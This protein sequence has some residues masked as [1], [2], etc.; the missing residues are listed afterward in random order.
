MGPQ[1][2]KAFHPASTSQS[3]SSSSQ[4]SSNLNRP[5]DAI[6]AAPALTNLVEES[7]ETANKSSAEGISLVKNADGFDAV[8]TN[9]DP[10]DV[11]ERTEQRENRG[12]GE[13]DFECWR[14]QLLAAFIRMM[15]VLIPS[16]TMSGGAKGKRKNHLGESD[17]ED[18]P[19]R[20][21]WRTLPDG[22]RRRDYFPATGYLSTTLH[23]PRLHPV[24][25]SSQCCCSS[26][27]MSS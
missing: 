18:I 6:H 16:L 27:A 10:N 23:D 3:T 24:S 19:E 25:I 21:E 11:L 26:Y 5:K 4:H 22:Y 15:S 12:N 20:V 14:S 8:H 1:Y 7:P 2:L 17:E 13:G 9:D